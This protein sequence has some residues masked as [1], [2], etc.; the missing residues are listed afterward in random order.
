MARVIDIAPRDEEAIA[1][2]RA[3]FAAA[4]AS[5]T[6][7]SI[8][9][10]RHSMGGQSLPI[11]GIV[12]NMLPHDHTQ[13][14]R[15]TNLI[16]V[17][18][19]ATWDLVVPYLDRFGRSI[20]VMQSD[21]SFSVGGSVSVNAH[22]WQAGRPPIVSTVERITMVLPDGSVK[23]CS[24]SE[25]SDLFAAAIGGYGMFGVILDVTL[26]PVPNQ[27]LRRRTVRTTVKEFERVY[28]REL[29]K[30]DVSLAYGR[31]SVAPGAPFLD[32][33]ILTT[34]ADTGEEPEPLGS[35]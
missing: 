30:G 14:D 8:A 15:K 25:N 20:E 6:P 17:G 27:S 5:G 22:G 32:E 12:L 7:L 33:T 18:A 11:S 24:R 31:I 23:Q 35:L 10:T 1:Q 4:K 9:G 13:F 26:R 21:S 29:A 2:I 3:A 19:G 28:E 34:Y 16:T